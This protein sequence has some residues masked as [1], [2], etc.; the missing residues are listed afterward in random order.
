LG[1]WTNCGPQNPEKPEQSLR[2]Q[3]IFEE[4]LVP[5]G[6]PILMDITCG[7]V[8]QTMTRPQGNKITFNTET[9]IIKVIG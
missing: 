1:A 6:K 8:L 7:H 5:T 3:T 4:I 9:Q 2:L